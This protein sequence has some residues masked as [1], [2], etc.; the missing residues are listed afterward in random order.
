MKAGQSGE[1][2]DLAGYAG[3]R[4]GAQQQPM[5]QDSFAEGTRQNTWHQIVI[6]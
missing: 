1:M 6:P 4:E 3:A 2:V 5:K